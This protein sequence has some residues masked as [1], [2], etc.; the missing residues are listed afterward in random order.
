MTTNPPTCGVL[1]WL[2]DEDTV[3]LQNL[4]FMG[5]IMT[6][7]DKELRC[8]MPEGHLDAHVQFLMDQAF[9][10]PV[11][12]WASWRDG[13]LRHHAAMFTGPGCTATAPGSTDECTLL[14]GHLEF[15]HGQHL[16]DSDS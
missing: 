9:T 1:G 15:T 14:D 2:T 5:S 16:F 10:K 8:G 13:E 12:W 7:D 4:A 11:Y 3:R 6:L